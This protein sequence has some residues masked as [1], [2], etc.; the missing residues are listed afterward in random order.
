MLENTIYTPVIPAWNDSSPNFLT[1]IIP[2]SSSL[3]TLYYTASYSNLIIAVQFKKSS[4]EVAGLMNYASRGLFLSG[5]ANIQ[6]SI[7]IDS[8]GSSDISVSFININPY[9]ASLNVWFNNQKASNTLIIVLAVLGGI[10]FLGLVV[11]AVCVIK[12]M[13]SSPQQ[14]NPL[15]S[16][17]R[18]SVRAQNANDLNNQEIETYFPTVLCKNVINE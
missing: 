5:S 11:V 17:M 12:K 16:M 4:A 10:L 15:G 1:I 2:A 13:R 18:G 3:T 9:P 8:G 14:V 6:S 7:P